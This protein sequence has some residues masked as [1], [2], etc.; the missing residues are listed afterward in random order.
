MTTTFKSELTCGFCGKSS[1]YTTIGSSG[2]YEA[3]DLDMRPGELYRSTMD[4]WV[5]RCPHCGYCNSDIEKAAEGIKE[6]VNSTKYKKIINNKSDFELAHSFL[7]QSYIYEI[8]ED[9]STSAWAQIHAAWCN[10]S[11]PTGLKPL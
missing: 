7:A 1:N 9:Y 6:I 11:K 10:P 8:L 4:C 5:Y 2:S 3:P